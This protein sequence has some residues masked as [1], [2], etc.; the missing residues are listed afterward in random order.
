M[1][2]RITKRAQR[3]AARHE[4]HWR[5]TKEKAP[6]LFATELR[7]AFQHLQTVP[8]AGTPFPTAKKPGLRRV[9]MERTGYHVYFVVHDHFDE[10]RI[11]V[12]WGARRGRAPGF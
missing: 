10:I 12:V 7:A 9:L 8:G 2:L 5:R 3:D 11:M 1:K 6:E 4:A